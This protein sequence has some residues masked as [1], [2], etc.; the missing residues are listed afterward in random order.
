MRLLITLYSKCLPDNNNLPGILNADPIFFS[1][2][3]CTSAEKKINAVA[4]MT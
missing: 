1:M 3:W 2:D 4:I